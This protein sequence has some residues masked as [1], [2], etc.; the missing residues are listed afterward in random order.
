MMVLNLAGSG[1]VLPLSVRHATLRRAWAS[2]LRQSSAYCRKL[3]ARMR[4]VLVG[5]VAV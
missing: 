5:A 2:Y 3:L 4:A 1:R